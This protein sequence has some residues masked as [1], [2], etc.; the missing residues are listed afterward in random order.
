M[1]KLLVLSLICTASA[2]CAGQHVINPV[3]GQ[4]KRVFGGGQPAQAI[5]IAPRAI[6]DRA[7][8]TVMTVAPGS[9]VDAAGQGLSTR[10]RETRTDG[11]RFNV[12]Q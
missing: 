2:I 4:A 3:A 1:K 10:A 11:K 5:K 12:W 6:A 9:K 8:R 7:N